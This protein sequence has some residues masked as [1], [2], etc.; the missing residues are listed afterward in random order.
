M[1]GCKRWKLCS[2]HW[3][4]PQRATSG[5]AWR[6]R[7]RWR[8]GREKGGV[9]VDATANGNV[10]SGPC[11]SEEPVALEEQMWPLWRH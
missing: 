1:L 5:G 9:T 7:V 2:S 8:G 4:F 11:W 10:L 6:K 3:L